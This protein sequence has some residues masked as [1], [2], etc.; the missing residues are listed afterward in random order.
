MRVLT[1]FARAASSSFCH[2]VLE[3]FDAGLREAGHTYEL[4]DLYAIGFDPVLRERDN[5]NWMDADAPDDDS[6]AARFSPVRT[7]SAPTAGVLAL[8]AALS[9]A[10]VVASSA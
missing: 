4:V 8:G 10:A 6:S 5:P 3:R 1:V 2:A 9:N 7:C